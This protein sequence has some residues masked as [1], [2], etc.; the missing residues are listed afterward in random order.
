MI[1]L[2]NS[3]SNFIDITFLNGCSPVNLLH[4]LITPFPKNTSGW[5]LLMLSTLSAI[6]GLLRCFFWQV[7]IHMKDIGLSHRRLFLWPGHFTRQPETRAGS[8]SYQFSCSGARN[9]FRRVQ[10]PGYSIIQ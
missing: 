10:F 1:S 6:K 5:L 9:K 8:F 4:S 7:S 3:T 2:K